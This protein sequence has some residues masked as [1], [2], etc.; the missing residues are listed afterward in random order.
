MNDVILKKVYDIKFDTM[1]DY[2]SSYLPFYVSRSIS[3]FTFYL[4]SPTVC[5]SALCYKIRVS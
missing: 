1:S 4:A 3:L 5:R 2:L